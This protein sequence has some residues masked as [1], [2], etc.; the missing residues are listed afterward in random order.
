MKTQVVAIGASLVD[1]FVTRTGRWLVRNPCN[2][3][4]VLRRSTCGRMRRSHFVLMVAVALA[5][6]GPTAHSWSAGHSLI[7][8]AVL[9]MMPP[10]FLESLNAKHTTWPPESGPSG[11]LT[12][13]VGGA[14]AESGDTVAGPCA[15]AIATPC[16]APAVR[17]K[18]A[19]RDY[20]CTF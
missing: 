6:S 4:A 17:A 14:W 2:S 10:G 12:G 16:G 19:L 13:F 20:C 18:M 15:P 1:A 9:T 8:K 5:A 11:N 3:P 7:N